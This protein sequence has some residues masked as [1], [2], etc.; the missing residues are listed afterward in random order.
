MKTH[1]KFKKGDKVKVDVKDASMSH[2]ET[3]FIGTVVG[4]C[5]EQFRIDKKKYTIKHPKYGKIS[6]YNE[7]DLEL[8][9]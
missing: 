8:V 1:Q 7:Y 4:S 3:D 9:K 5:Y 2:F 6:W